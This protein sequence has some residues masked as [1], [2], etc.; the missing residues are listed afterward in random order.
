MCKHLLPDNECIEGYEGLEEN[1]TVECD[2]KDE[3]CSFYEE[4]I[5]IK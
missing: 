4:E 1:F 5:C 2:G 3:E